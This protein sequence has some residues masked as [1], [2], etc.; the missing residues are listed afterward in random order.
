MRDAFSVV[1]KP[2]DLHSTRAWIP[3]CGE[4]LSALAFDIT[5]TSYILEGDE[6]LEKNVAKGK[7]GWVAETSA[8]GN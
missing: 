1:E 5:M 7:P 8:L 3:T 6:T 4:F 2:Y